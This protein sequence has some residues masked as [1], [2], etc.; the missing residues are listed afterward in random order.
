[1]SF[2]CLGPRLEFAALAEG[3]GVQLLYGHELLG[4]L[5]V[6]LE[7]V[8]PCVVCAFGD[9]IAHVSSIANDFV[10]N[11]GS[12]F[13]RNHCQFHNLKCIMHVL[14]LRFLCDHSKYQSKQFLAQHLIH[15][16]SLMLCTS[17]LMNRIINIDLRIYNST[18]S[19]NRQET[20]T[21]HACFI[22][23]R[24][25]QAPNHSHNFAVLSN[26]HWELKG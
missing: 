18:L 2:L 1:M 9:G 15:S 21:L 3:P 13:L 11:Y 25:E 23:L 17:Y 12:Q 6:Q 5:G 4:C 8:H 10:E 16:T 14:N 22:V 26:L 7:E 19:N 24:A 20:Q